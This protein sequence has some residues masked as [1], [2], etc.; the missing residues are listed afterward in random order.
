MAGHANKG[1]LRMSSFRIP[2]GLQASLPIPA[3]YSAFPGIINGGIVSTIFDCHG[4]RCGFLLPRSCADDLGRDMLCLK[5][6][7][8][9]ESTQQFFAHAQ[10]GC[11]SMQWQSYILASVYIAEFAI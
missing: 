11:R 9:Y 4:A 7:L 5:S 3:Q 8:A 10:A 1:G 2:G 6:V